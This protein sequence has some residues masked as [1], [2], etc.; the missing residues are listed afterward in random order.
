MPSKHTTAQGH[1]RKTTSNDQTLL[2]QRARHNQRALE[3]RL[4][5]QQRELEQV[6]EQYREL[7]LDYSHAL[8]RLWHLNNSSLIYRNE[9]CADCGGSVTLE[10]A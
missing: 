9:G 8:A 1:T 10:V 7:Q 2:L 3:E 5:D 6:R 4:E